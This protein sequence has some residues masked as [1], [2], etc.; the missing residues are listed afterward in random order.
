MEALQL[1]LD[2]LADIQ[3]FLRL[4]EE[5]M[6]DAITVPDGWT[7]TTLGAIGNYLNGR[8]FKRSEW[9]P[10]G[11]PIIRIQDLTGSNVNP[12]H[13][14]GDA[15]PRYVVTAGDL[16]ISWS[17][18]LGAYIWNGPEAV[19][20]QH[21]F[22]V[23]SKINKRFHY[24]LVRDC[25]AELDRNAHGSG[26]VHVTKGVF[27][28]TPVAVPDDPRL[29]EA[30]AA[31]IDDAERFQASALAH[32]GTA[33]HAVERLRRAVLATACSGG[34]TADW[35]ERRHEQSHELATLSEAR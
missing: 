17:A 19:L 2:D 11:R 34:L 31:L 4:V 25:L 28:N 12:N 1:A 9:S 7:A 33:S 30:L 27:D 5:L 16:L 35:R 24:H 8:A 23:E 21:I 18:T 20:N 26:M 6:S 13:F 10:T 3:R 29:Q 22:K 14:E 32:L 15:E